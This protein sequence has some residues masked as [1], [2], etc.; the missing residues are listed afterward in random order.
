MSRETSPYCVGDHWLDKRRDGQSPDVWQIATYNPKSRSPVY[1]S[2]KQRDLGAA[3]SVIH[4]FVEKARAKSSQS[5]DDA[6]IV[7]QLILY[8]EEHGKGVVNAG[9]IDR[10]LR[11]FIGFLMQDEIGVNATIADIRP[12]VI[13]RFIAWR[14]H[15]HGYKLPWRNQ[16]YD[17]TSD[18]VTGAAVQRNINDIRA[19]INHA[20][21]NGRIPYAPRI[22]AVPAK[23]KSPPRDFRYSIDQ[24]GA[25]LGYAQGEAPLHRWLALLMATAMRPDAALA[26]E[27]TARQWKEAAG[28]LDLHPPAWLRT[29]KHNPI[30]QAIAPFRPMLSDW[31]AN[32]HRPAL[33]RKRSWGTLREALGLPAQAIP[34]AIRHSIATELRRRGVSIDRIAAQLGHSNGNRTT[35]IYADYDPEFMGN[36]PEVL[37]S[38]FDEIIEASKV[39]S[40]DH[41]L[42]SGP[43]GKKIVIAK[44]EQ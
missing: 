20:A 12:V 4:A 31:K 9:N 18:G 7:P 25:M 19:A 8:F 38:I 21:N 34:K 42:T 35:A 1:R 23:F 15:E 14:M 28:L 16:E 10:S 5:A 11:L 32:P 44:K 40:A 37:T 36:L 43:K 27:P 3:K 6:K 33:S 2:T 29:K 30:V 17:F 26:F 22:P 13:N 24:M 41:L 39:W